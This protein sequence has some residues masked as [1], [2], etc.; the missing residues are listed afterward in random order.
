[1]RL[2]K[3]IAIT[4]L[5]SRKSHHVVWHRINCLQL[6][7]KSIDFLNWWL[8]VMFVSCLTWS[9]SQHY[10]CQYYA[11]YAATSKL[12]QFCC[13]VSVSWRLQPTCHN[14]QLF[15]SLSQP[16]NANTYY[17][18]SLHVENLKWHEDLVAKN[19]LQLWGLEQ[20][21][22]EASKYS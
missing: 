12:N 20:V 19:R 13:V 22:I 6:L 11:L 1:M 9:S 18:W 8:H 7:G 10:N 17:S 3:A 4:F 15:A 14:V 5:S 21:D 16:F 2:Y